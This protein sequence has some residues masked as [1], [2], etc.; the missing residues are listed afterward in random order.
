MYY[1]EDS[2][3]NFLYGMPISEEAYND[4]KERIEIELSIFEDY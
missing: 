4:D 3:V 2:F 1:E